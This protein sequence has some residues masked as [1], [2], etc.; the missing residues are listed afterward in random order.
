MNLYYSIFLNL[1]KILNA[2]SLSKQASPNPVKQSGFI[3]ESETE[4]LRRDVFRPDMEKFLLFTQMLRTNKMYN[5]V[6]V[7]HK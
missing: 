3:E 7:A 5:R 6:K 4:R 2:M 1:H